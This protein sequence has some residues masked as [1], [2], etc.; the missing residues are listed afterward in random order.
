MNLLSLYKKLSLFPCGRW[1]FTQAVCFRAPYFFSISPI[2]TDL[3][4]TRCEVLLKKRHKVYNHIKT[5]HAI[6]LCNA[7]ELAM[8][9]LMEASLPRHLRW[10][11]KGMNVQYLKKAPTN[12]RAIAEV[13]ELPQMKACELPVEVALL[14]TNGVEVAHATIQV[15]ITEKTK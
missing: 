6:A 4:T 8:G 3:T 9:A 11:P 1:L 2:I 10:I 12:V 7:A 15:W 5:V 13:K 14:D